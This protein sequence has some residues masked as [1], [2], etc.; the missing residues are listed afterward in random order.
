MSRSARTIEPGAGT[1]IS[2]PFGQPLI[3][4]GR[5][6][7]NEQIGLLESELRAGGGF[8]MPHWHDDLDETFYVLD[9]EIEYLLDG[10]WTRAC[11]GTTVF[12]PAGT[13]HA[14]RNRSTANARHL[15]IGSV[16]AV[17]LVRALGATGREDWPTVFRAYRSHVADR[18]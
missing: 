12:V 16:D 1:P 7:G 10:E 6:D 9:G 5:G 8:Q 15:V 4:V 11:A 17:E 3:K 2:L 13:V 14:F 18:V